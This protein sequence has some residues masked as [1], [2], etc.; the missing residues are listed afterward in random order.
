VKLDW[1]NS[2]TLVRLSGP[3]LFN[4]R[5]FA[6]SYLFL[7]IPQILFDVV[8]FESSTWLW[9]PIWTA[10]H[11]A[12]GL[13]AFYIRGI[14]L[15][16]YLEKNPSVLLNLA[17]AALLGILRVGIIG[18]TSFRLG[19]APDFDLFARVISGTILGLFMFSFL[20]VVLSSNRD[21]QRVLGNLLST[22]TQL[23]NLR[24][25]KQK[26]IQ[27]TQR[28]LEMTTRSVIEPRLQ[29]IA[30][31]LK[32]E[33]IKGST[34]NALTNELKDLLQNQVRPLSQGLRT[35]SRVLADPKKFRAVSRFGLLRIPDRMNPDLALRPIQTFLTLAAIVPF[36]LYIFEN[37]DWIPTG[38][39]LALTNL[40]SFWV[41]RK[42]LQPLPSIP[43]APGI[44]LLFA[45]VLS[46]ALL[47]YALLLLFGFPRIAAGYVGLVI[48][49][50][51]FGTTA[52]YG[53]VATYEYNQ[54]NF[55]KKLSKN[56][57]RLERELALLNQRL[58]VEKREWALRLHGSVQASLTAA[59]ARLSGITPVANQELKLI[60]QHINQARKALSGSPARIPSLAESLKAL[61][62]TWQGIVKLKVDLKSEKAQ[63]ISADKWASA[64]ANEIIKESVS[65]SVKHGKAQNIQVRFEGVDPGFVEIVVQ[66]DGKG[67]P[68]QFRPG[69]GSQLLDEIAYPW[70]L[71]RQSEGGV[72]LRARIPVA[73]KKLATTT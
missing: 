50:A 36:S 59:I 52:G 28:E 6:W 73:R 47:D 3:G 7:F 65:N 48:F 63:Q 15:D 41:L 33:T 53:L 55:L 13:A 46:Q 34:R 1:R 25:S 27:A 54:E 58:W 44:L 49:I 14:G 62:D 66:D 4:L 10:G 51:L 18:Y 9:L 16:R 40:L 42:L 31:A 68:A 67:L 29:E 64:C 26:E 24:K 5:L 21:Y 39:L 61:R 60:R 11:L 32:A 69:L 17:V 37:Q 38:F 43:T 22:Q 20:S 71:T 23:S 30:L 56:N 2:K 72:I 8:A 19:L 45:F 35:T 57:K 12:A 70:S